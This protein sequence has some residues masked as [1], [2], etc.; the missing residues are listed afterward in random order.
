MKLTR[1][2]RVLSEIVRVLSHLVALQL[3]VLTRA[4][5]LHGYMSII[6][7]HRPDRS[8]SFTFFS[9]LIQKS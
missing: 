3:F 5:C 2:L 9:G 6:E 7:L 8:S 4:A 1:S